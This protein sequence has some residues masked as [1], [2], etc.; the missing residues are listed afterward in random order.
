MSAD[1]SDFTESSIPDESVVNGDELLAEAADRYDATARPIEEVL[2]EIAATVPD[3]EWDRLPP[4]LTDNL[5]HYIYG[6]PKR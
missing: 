1:A 3:E 5:D 2:A 6:T 4:D